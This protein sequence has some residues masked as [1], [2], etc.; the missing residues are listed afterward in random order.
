MA[1]KKTKKVSVKKVS[2]QNPLKNSFSV[3]DEEMAFR[4]VKLYFEEV[5][6]LGFKRTLDLDA[7][8]NAYFYSLARLKRKEGEMKLIKE[9]VLKEETELASETKEQLFPE[10]EN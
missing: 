1:K 3:P 4:M 2:V 5:A 6:R 7:I 9:K 10:P 8:I